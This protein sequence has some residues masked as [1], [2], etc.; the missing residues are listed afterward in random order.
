MNKLIDFVKKKK[1]LNNEDSNNE[2]YKQ[3]FINYS[4]VLSDSRKP[5]TRSSLV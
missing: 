3:I 4:F 1:Q 5:L 2:K